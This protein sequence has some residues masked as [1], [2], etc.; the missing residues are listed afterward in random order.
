MAERPTFRI[1]T[2][3]K[4]RE[5]DI[6]MTALA[7][8][9]QDFRL[10]CLREAPD[11]FASTYE[12]ESQRGLEHSV[13]RLI[14]PKAAQF[15]ALRDPDPETA[16]AAR[17]EDL[18]RL[19][20]C[21][22]AGINVLLGPEEGSDLPAPSAHLDRFPRGDPFQQMTTAKLS[23]NSSQ[24]AGMPDVLHFHINGMFVSPSTR[25]AGL[26]NALMDGVL[27]RAEEEAARTNSSLHITISVFA[28]NVAAM[29]LYDKAGFVVVEKSQS[30][31]RP[32]FM[33]VHMELNRAAVR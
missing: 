22:W 25:G 30:R 9:F 23:L 11:S 29:H 4:I 26:G 21:E 12:V 31:S 10:H 7:H 28:H 8:K 2:I 16:S 20:N 14:N 13:Q 6:K 33:A 27:R 24:D 32:E 18:D 19:L 5:T 3:P 15:V 1:V 17:S